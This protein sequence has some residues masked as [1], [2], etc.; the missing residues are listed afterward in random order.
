MLFDPW[1]ELPH[2]AIG[3]SGVVAHPLPRGPGIAARAGTP[4]GIRPLINPNCL[5]FGGGFCRLMPVVAGVEAE[6]VDAAQIAV[7]LGVI[8]P[9]ADD[10][11]IGNVEANIAD[12]QL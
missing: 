9:V 8:H 5:R 6:L 1:V 11:I 4:L 10:E 12:R 2:N 3:F 7:A